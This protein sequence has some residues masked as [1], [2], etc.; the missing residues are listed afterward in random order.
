VLADAGDIVAM[1]CRGELNISATVCYSQ[2]VEALPALSVYEPTV[3]VF[4]CVKTSTF[5]AKEGKFVPSR[6]ILD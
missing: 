2:K 1:T 4:F 5:C 3:S 6:P